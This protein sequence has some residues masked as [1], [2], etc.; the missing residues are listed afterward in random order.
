V[1]ESDTVDAASMTYRLSAGTLPGNRLTIN[2]APLKV[3]PSGAT[4]G[5][6][7]LNVGE[8]R[9]TLTATTPKGDSVSKSFLVVRAKPPETS[10]DSVLAID[11][12]MTEPSEELWLDEDDRLEVQFKGTPGRK[13]SND[14]G[15]PM[16]EVKPAYAHGLGGIYRGVYTVKDGDTLSAHQVKFRLEDSTGAFVEAYSK[17]AVTM[18]P[19][20]FPYIGVTKGERPALSYGLGE[21]RLGGAK[22]SFINAGIRLA[23]TGKHGPMYRVA[24]APGHEAWI[25]AMNVDLIPRGARLPSALT[26][27]WMVTGDDKYDYVTVAMPLRLPYSSTT[28]SNPSRITIDVYGATSNTNWIIQQLT[29]REITNVYYTE[30]ST[31]V[32]RITIELKHKQIWGY[33]ISYNPGGLVVKVRRQPEKLKIKALT[34]ALDA[35]HGGENLGAL[36]S[37]GVLEKEINLAIVKE[38]KAMLEDR[39]ARVILTR[40]SDADV[41]MSDRVRKVITSGADILISIHSN[42][43]GLTTNPELTRGTATFYK[44][45]CYRP[46]ALAIVK[47][48]LKTGLPLFGNVGSFN[49]SLNSPTELPNVLLE[50]AFVSNPTDE[51]NLIDPEFRHRLAQ[52]VVD[53]IDDFLDGCDE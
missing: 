41:S 19:G 8:N 20:D 42:S 38:L 11:T 5:L 40:E 48:V 36:G 50:T 33:E 43:I 31:G 3:Y 35:G 49:F 51:M 6:L 14:L 39:G 12:I 37:T 52:R 2:G 10:P 30:P 46:L 21:D 44:H 4:A 1:P 18:R 34:F 28:E 23:I 27:N 47:E 7:N 25:S 16:K 29:A 9:F 17:G 45:I 13:A 26:E 32:F 24:L 22:M 15:I 53:G